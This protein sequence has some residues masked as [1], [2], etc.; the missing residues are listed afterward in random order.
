MDILL[1]GWVTTNYLFI[2]L[3]VKSIH[4]FQNGHRDTRSSLSMV[5]QPQKLLKERNLDSLGSS[6]FHNELEGLTHVYRDN[7]SVWDDKRMVSD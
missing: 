3:Y 1:W 4:E 2:F 7:Y 5:E 6:T